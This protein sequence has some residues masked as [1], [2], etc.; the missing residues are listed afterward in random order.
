[1]KGY[2]GIECSLVT[3]LDYETS[4]KVLKTI[5]PD[6]L[7]TIS[8][9]NGSELV[10][11]GKPLVADLNNQPAS[12]EESQVGYVIANAEVTKKGSLIGFEMIATA[13][14]TINITVFKF[15]I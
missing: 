9:S 8:S 11:Y 3:K 12:Y 2:A 5:T 14:G 10:S 15:N 6:T 13:A 4:V 1:M 7:T